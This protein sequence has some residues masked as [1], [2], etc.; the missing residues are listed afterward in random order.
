MNKTHAQEVEL[1]PISRNREK[2]FRSKRYIAEESSSRSENSLKNNFKNN[3]VPLASDNRKPKGH[4]RQIRSGF[5]TFNPGVA[6]DFP[7]EVRDRE[8]PTTTP[9]TA[10]TT[11]PTTTPTTVKMNTSKGENSPYLDEI[12]SDISD[13]WDALNITAKFLKQFGSVIEDLKSR[14]GLVELTTSEIEQDV[15]KSNSLLKT[16]ILN[17]SRIVRVTKNETVGG[18]EGEEKESVVELPPSKDLEAFNDY[19]ENIGNMRKEDIQTFGHQR[20]DFIA[21]CSWQGGIC[22][23]RFVDKVE[24]ELLETYV[25]LILWAPGI[26]WEN[27]NLL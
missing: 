21:I 2:D 6:S 24:I 5:T 10:P 26:G 20:Q 1:R 22:Y 17:I 14:L 15:A 12:Q 19:L 9:T 11:T 8:P 16:T 23:P 7:H 25:I 18:G 13:L 27:E 3:G 4:K